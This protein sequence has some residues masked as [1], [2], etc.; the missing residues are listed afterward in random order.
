MKYRTDDLA[1]LLSTDWFLQLWG[2]CGLLSPSPAAAE[3]NRQCREIVRDFVGEN[4]RYWDV[5]YSRS[6][7]KKTEDRFLQAMS[8]A[9]LVAHDRETLSGLN[10]GQSSNTHS[11]ENTS[12]IFNLLMLLTS[13]GVA[14]KDMRDG[15]TP[16][17]FQKIQASLAKHA[18]E[19]RSEIV[20]AASQAR[21]R[22]D[23]WA[24]Q[25]TSEIPG[26][27]LGVARDVYDYNGPAAA[28]WGSLRSG[29]SESEMSAL[30]LWLNHWG[31]ELAGVAVIDPGEVH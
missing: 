9:R 6:R 7:M 10:Q 30:K 25:I 29:M 26:L 15:I 19:D 14:D 4:T 16:S 2:T 18:D 20:G 23:A 24:A 21:T 17:M 31:Q 11:L 12:L 13:N 5:E 27:L 22:W 28:L 8:V 1:L 3:M